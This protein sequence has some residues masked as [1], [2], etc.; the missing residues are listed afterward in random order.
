MYNHFAFCKWFNGVTAKSVCPFFKI[1]VPRWRMR[2]VVLVMNQQRELTVAFGS[3]FFPV[4]QMG[5][6]PTEVHWPGLNFHMDFNCSAFPWILLG[7]LDFCTCRGGY[8]FSR[9][10]QWPCLNVKREPK[11]CRCWSNGQ[12]LYNIIVPAS[13]EV[14]QQFFHFHPH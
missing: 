14:K 10:H 3:F 11:H 4:F 5:S 6:P 9:Q 1:N 2:L 8:C 7:F 13:S 12:R